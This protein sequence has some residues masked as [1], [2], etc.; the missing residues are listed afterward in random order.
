VIVVAMRIPLVIATAVVLT[1]ALAVGVV[2]LGA[3]TG[4]DR[5]L[6]PI[7]VRAPAVP[8]PPQHLPEPAPRDPEGYVAPPPPV[9]DDDG[10]RPDDDDGADDD[11]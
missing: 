9:A 5:P 11:D 2:S 10:N 6:E 1:V 3:T 4:A 8:A 7:T